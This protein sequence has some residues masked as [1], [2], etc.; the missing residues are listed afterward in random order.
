MEPQTATI[1]G[2]DVGK[3]FLYIAAS[4]GDN[5]ITIDNTPKAIRAWLKTIPAHS[6]IAMEATGSYHKELLKQAHQRG[7]SAYVVSGYQL[8]HY[9]A[10][11]GKRAKTDVGDA[12][13][14]RRFLSSEQQNLTPW[15][16]PEKGYEDVQTLL[17]R[18][19]TL[20]KHSVAIKQSLSSVPCLAADTK[21]L[22]KRMKKMIDRLS[23]LITQGMKKG[24][25]ENDVKRCQGIEGIGPVVG[26][27]IALAFHR[28]T[29]HSA[30]AFIAFLGMDV[31]AKDS[32]TLH[33]KRKLSKQGD[34]ES[35]RL[36]YLAAMRACRMPAWE[37]FYQRQLQH[38]LHR[39]QA[40]VALARK[41]A[42][43]AFSLLKN[44]ATYI[45]HIPQK[46]KMG[47]A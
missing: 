26:P 39:T 11:I 40:L 41:L 47:V 32:S 8:K 24:G 23:T 22:L 13:L 42:R 36:L 19:S 6:S 5:V 12:L 16:P 45:P 31:V 9:R 35:R 34:P 37:P 20:V 21:A 17:R 18:R 27:A 30:D 46:M 2:V 7:H 14:A 43:V 38:G 44:Q 4:K 25:W 28:G 10:S 33:G 15:L 3:D 1:I 29:F